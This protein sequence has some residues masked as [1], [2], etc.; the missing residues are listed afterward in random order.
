MV[1][2][3]AKKTVKKTTHTYSVEQFERIFPE[4]TEQVRDKIEP[5]FDK[6]FYPELRLVIC[7]MKVKGGKRVIVEYLTQKSK[8][9]TEPVTNIFMSAWNRKADAS[10][11]DE[12]KDYGVQVKNP[13]TSA[14]TEQIIKEIRR[15][16]GHKRIHLDELDYGSGD[17]GLLAKVYNEFK[18]DDNSLWIMYSATPEEMLCCQK[19]LEI[20]DNGQGVFVEIDPPAA[21]MGIKEYIDRGLVVESHSLFDFDGSCLTGHGVS[22]FQK[23]AMDYMGNKNKNVCIIRVNGRHEKKNRFNWVRENIHIVQDYFDQEVGPECMVVRLKDIGT[24]SS[25]T[26]KWEDYDEWEEKVTSYFFVYLVEQSACRATEFRCH[27]RL[28]FYHSHRYT[29]E[30]NINTIIQD[31]ER[32]V[33]Y[34]LDRAHAHATKYPKYVNLVPSCTIYG[35]HDVAMYSAGFITLEDLLVKRKDLCPSSRTEVLNNSSK[36]KPRTYEAGTEDELYDILRRDGYGNVSRTYHIDERDEDGFIKCI[37]R[38]QKKVYTYDNILKTN[39]GIHA[40]KIGT[41]RSFVCYRDITDNKSEVFVARVH[42]GERH[43]ERDISTDA[44]SSMYSK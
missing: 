2:R 17:D 10:Q 43:M 22:V 44:P 11:R 19:W 28:N 26:V 15:M 5:L 8:H 7:K 3:A 21:Y 39:Y 6:A 20:E 36:I 12:L 30:Q 37:I 16:P 18:D 25:N 33:Y 14:K 13:S 41:G 9:A 40:N 35:D 34:K 24:K 38:S 1:G 4:M 32:C 23:A 42:V 29:S 31:Q 27:H